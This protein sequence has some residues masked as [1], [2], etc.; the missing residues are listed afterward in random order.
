MLMEPPQTPRA[1]ARVTATRTPKSIKKRTILD[2]NSSYLETDDAT[3]IYGG[4]SDEDDDLESSILV[5]DADDS[6]DV[7]EEAAAKASSEETVLDVQAEE[8]VLVQKEYSA[9]H[10]FIVKHEVIRKVFHSSIGVVTLWLYTLGVNQQQ[11]VVPLLALFAVIFANDYLRLHN[12]ELN[13][14][15]VSAFWFVIRPSEVHQ[16]NGV[17]WYLVGLVFVFAV[18]PKDI[19]LMSVLLLSWA[20]TAASTFGRQFGKYTPKF[21]NGKSVAGSIASGVTGVL[22]CYLLYSYFIPVYNDKVNVPGDI[23][24]TPESSKLNLHV[25]ALLSGLIASVSEFIDLFGLDDNFT[26]PVMSGTFLLGVVHWFQ[27]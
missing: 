14:K 10:N 6:T 3:Y 12:P 8:P 20:D 25:Y 4:S 24:W 1:K 23:L 18:A 17:L 27:V 9:V 22:S 15:I 13:A 5:E 11:L 2:P 7:E 16:Y 19:S 26:I 21:A